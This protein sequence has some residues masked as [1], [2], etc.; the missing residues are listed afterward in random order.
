LA[1]DVTAALTRA[2]DVDTDR[3]TVSA[4]HGVVTLSG[5]VDVAG[6]RSAPQ[7]V[8]HQVAGVTA[9][10][11]ELSVLHAGSAAAVPPGNGGAP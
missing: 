11:N 9:V 8:A 4:N 1:S 10:R 5:E 3:L 6:D 7:S 2:S